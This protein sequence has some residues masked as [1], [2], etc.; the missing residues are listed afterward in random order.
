[1][2]GTDR[3]QLVPGPRRYVE[4]LRGLLAP[5][6]GPAYILLTVSALGSSLLGLL[7]LPYCRRH[8]RW[9][10]LLLVGGVT[11]MNLTL[12]RQ[13]PPHTAAAV[14]YMSG[15]YPVAQIGAW[16]LIERLRNRPRIRLLLIG[17]QI[18]LFAIFSYLF[19]LKQFL[20]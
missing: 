9:S 5:G 7:C 18:Y 4:H 20:G 1:M 19:G 6:N 12:M 13:V 16:F 15:L 2:K 10:Y 17:V 14:R 11:M 8:F 3:E